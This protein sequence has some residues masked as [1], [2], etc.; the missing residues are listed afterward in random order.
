MEDKIKI[1]DLTI[2]LY[3]TDSNTF[4]IRVGKGEIT[5]DGNVLRDYIVRGF[6]SGLRDLLQVGV[7]DATRLNK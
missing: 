6:S 2:E 5:L 4:L 1:N 7:K 3:D